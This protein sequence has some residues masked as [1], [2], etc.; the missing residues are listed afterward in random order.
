MLRS[1]LL[2]VSMIS[3]GA[4][5]QTAVEQSQAEAASHTDSAL[6]EALIGTWEPY[7][8]GYQPLGDLTMGAEML[9]WGP[10][11]NVR[12]RVFRRTDK[13]YYIELVGE[14]PCTVR[15][16]SHLVLVPAENSLE[17]SRC[18]GRDEFD[19]PP[20]KRYCSWGILYK[21]EQRD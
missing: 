10:C 9:S 6:P 4:C 5:A 13:A 2:A 20:E 17:V 14:P 3:A 1:L 21:K 8:R 12:Y 7:S 11:Q 19:K 16:A 18:R 15:G